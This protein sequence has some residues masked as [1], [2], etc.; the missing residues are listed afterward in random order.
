MRGSAVYRH[1]WGTDEVYGLFDDTPRLDEWLRILAA[2]AEAQADLGLIPSSAAQEIAAGA[3]LERL[4]LEYLIAQTRATQH[5]TLGLI[6]AVQQVLR[7]EA[8]EWYCYGATVQDV[9]DTWTAL[10][11]A[12]MV[13]ILERDLA[14]IEAFVLD[15]ADRHRDTGIAGRT[16]WQIGLPITF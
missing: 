6:R 11:M 12:R 16:H 2:L 14:T 15:L 3:R 9:S 7:P 5:S 1:L 8:G 13:T 4:D 10:I